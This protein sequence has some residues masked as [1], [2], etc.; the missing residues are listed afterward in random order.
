MTAGKVL[1]DADA[2]TAMNALVRIGD[3]VTPIALRVV[4]ELEIPDLLAGGPR[5]AAELAGVAGAHEP[6]LYRVLRALTANAVFHEDRT[7]RFSLTPISDLLREEHPHSMRGMYRLAPADLHAMAELEHGV[8]N[9]ISAF[10]H[11][12]GTTFWQYTQQHPEHQ[13]RYQHNMWSMATLEIPA[14][15]QVY[16]WSRVGHLVDLGGGT[17]Q[18]I[19]G[20]LAAH[21]RMRGSLID[22]PDV[23]PGSRTV[24]E[25]EGVLDRCEIVCGDFF[26]SV[27]SGGDVY[28]LKRVFYDFTD[29]QCTQILRSVRAAM[30]AHGRV[31]VLDGVVRSDNR[32]DAGKLHDL[33]VLAMGQ[34]RCRSRD[35]LAAIFAGA[36]LRLSR[37]IPTGAFPLVEGRAA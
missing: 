28:L 14:V 30:P 18:M 5:T 17:G 4:V 8:R 23:A 32:H 2:A 11:V 37:V 6:S 26:E 22:L 3:F 21:P 34:G 36:G 16:D 1:P 15:L 20:I 33:Y 35:E 24:L 27:P 13:R 29:E 19:A 31:L 10:E 7:H 12:H 25:A 9:P